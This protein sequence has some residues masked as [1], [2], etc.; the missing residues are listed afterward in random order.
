MA[1]GER[2][3][4]GPHHWTIRYDSG[5][6]AVVADAHVG[7]AWWSAD[8]T[9]RG[10]G[11][12]GAPVVLRH[13]WA[14][15]AIGYPDPAVGGVTTELTRDYATIYALTN[16]AVFF[17]TTFAQQFYVWVEGTGDGRALPTTRTDGSPFVEGVDY[18]RYSSQD[19]RKTY[20]AIQPG[21]SPYGEIPRQVAISFEL[22]QR[23][24]NNQEQLN[25]YD[26]VLADVA[27][28][29]PTQGFA[30][31]QEMERTRDHLRRQLTA[32]DSYLEY[33]R[34]LQRLFGIADWF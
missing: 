7:G 12:D 29:F 9:I 6:V 22:L 23:A 17:D 32:T 21:P 33:L 27:T 19:L 25:R 2:V 30:T 1:P 34:Q 20:V 24:K 13:L 4:H 11:I 31:R 3:A 15:P 26:Q 10:T 8:I 14:D 28:T 18:V 5:R 16:F